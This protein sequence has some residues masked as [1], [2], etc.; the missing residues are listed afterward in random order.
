MNSNYSWQKHQANEQLR[1]RMATAEIHRSRKFRKGTGGE[2]EDKNPMNNLKNLSVLIFLFIV[3]LILAACGGQDVEVKPANSSTVII[4]EVEEETVEEAGEEVADD[5]SPSPPTAKSGDISERAADGMVMVF[6]SQGM[7]P[8]G[9]ERG[10]SHEKPVHEV[11]LDAFWID[12][13]EVT[14]ERYLLCVNDGSCEPSAHAENED[15]NGSSQ[16]VVGVSWSGAQAYCEWAGGRLPTEAEWEYAAR[17]SDG[18]LYPWGDEFE[19]EK[20]NLCDTHCQSNRR[21]ERIDDG[22]EYTAPVGQYAAGA[23]WSGALDMSGN[24]QE[25]VSDWYDKAYYE[26]SAALNPQ[27]PDSGER[28]VLRGGSWNKGTAELSSTAR[29]SANPEERA[30]DAG[31]R[32]VVGLGTE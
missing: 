27:G 15:F 7:F 18:L 20:A 2:I 6:V 25:W 17:G 31:F 11:K 22:Y 12:R 5:T 26:N 29:V 19:S 14:N 4:E 9:G 13:T 24:V 10:F 32:C 23:S 16:P 28:K 8:M 3:G 30:D 21:D 1:A